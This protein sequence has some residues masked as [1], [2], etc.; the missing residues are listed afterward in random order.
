MIRFKRYL[1]L[2][3]VAAAASCS[4]APPHSAATPG[5]RLALPSPTGQYPVGT[6]SLRLINRAWRN[7][8]AS[9]P[10]YRELMTSIWYPARDVS[11]FPLAPQML[12]GA[13]AHFGGPMGDG[14]RQYFVPQGRVDWAATLT[15]GHEGAP[16]ALHRQALPVVLY[17]PDLQDPRTWGTTLVQDLASRGF[18]V[19]TI[20]HTYDSDAV[21][22]PNG[23]VVD[24]LAYQWATG[25][26]QHGFLSLLRKIVAVRTADARFVLDELTALNAGH[27]PDAEHRALPAGLAGALDLQRV[28]MFG[29]SLG[30]TTAFQAMSEDPRLKAAVDLDSN[31]GAP[32]LRSNQGDIAPVLRQGL[33]RPYMI[34]ANPG[35]DIHDIPSWKTFWERSTGW[36]LDLTLRN[37][38]GDSA[39][40]DM[41]S[42]AP[43]IAGKLGLL[44][45]F[46]THAIGT[47]DPATTVRAEEA[48]LA[49]FFD[50]WLL[51]RENHL[52]DGPSSAYPEFTFSAKAGGFPRS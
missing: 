45:S 15:S 32:Y 2:L 42:L 29:N 24:S 10:P 50:R 19:V 18:I 17:S 35:T 23:R 22:F 4:S 31:I 20:D 26:S 48:Y 3:A 11:R 46:V 39:Y 37:D 38:T 33:N 25:K 1:M 49:A 47:V 5:V 9:S 30:G 34:M 27:D 40:K 13:A 7:P 43:Q 36:R 41:A 14:T 6:V 51:G 44:H 21:Q 52:L 28:G 12:P 8:W 16:V